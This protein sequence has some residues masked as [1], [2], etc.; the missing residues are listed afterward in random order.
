VSAPWTIAIVGGSLAGLAAAA[1]LSRTTD[2]E[3]SVFEHT[4]GPL[5]GRGAG[6][7]MQPEIEYLLSVRDIRPA[8]V[9]VALRERQLLHRHSPPRTFAMP[10]TMTAWDTLYRAFRAVVPGV[11]YR[12]GV[13]VTGVTPGEQGVDLTFA[14]GSAST[15]T[16]VVGADGIGSTVRQTVSAAHPQ[17]TGYVAWR[18]LEAEDELPGDITGELTDRFTLYSANGIQ[19][20]CYLV[21]GPAGETSPGRRRVNW[22]W[23]VNASDEAF[24]DI[25]T[26]QSQ[27]RYDYFLPA[28]DVSET[29][30]ATLL[31]LADT[32]LPPLLSRLVRHSRPFLQPVMDLASA[33]MRCGP[34]FVIG[35]AA[36]TVRPHT[37]SGTSKSIAD[38]ALLANAL[39][40]W[41]PRDPLPEDELRVWEQHR[42]RSLQDLAV[43]GIGRAVTSRLGATDGTPVWDRLGQH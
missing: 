35:D 37:A 31:E 21:P 4:A 3:I 20:L 18:G 25:M 13:T 10:Q 12:Q 8:A 28:S 43:I 14:D 32:D 41:T 36:G 40:G 23:Y 2:A 1:E 29:S 33:R 27:R 9:S 22:V 42:L 34:V 30:M 26:G 39:R 16:L 19:F 38:A 6:I 5:E 17:Y 15:W 24:G 7:V 11:D